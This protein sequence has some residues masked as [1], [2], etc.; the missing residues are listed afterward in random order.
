MHCATRRYHE[1]AYLGGQRLLGLVEKLRRG[2]RA[3]VL[4]SLPVLC[5]PC[6]YASHNFLR[7]SPTSCFT[8]EAIISQL[9]NVLGQADAA[10]RRQLLDALRDLQL[11]TETPYE[12]LQRFAG[13]VRQTWKME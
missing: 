1:L 2:E 7:F 5:I 8:M 12:T 9:R 10:A 3:I 13:L 4:N 11:A 6:F